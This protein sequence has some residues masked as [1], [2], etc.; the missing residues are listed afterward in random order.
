MTD[1]VLSVSAIMH[2]FHKDVWIH[3][4]V[5]E[6]AV[7]C[8][9]QNYFP[10][11]LRP[12]FV[13]FLLIHLSP[14]QLFRAPWPCLQKA[15]PTPSVTSRESCH[16]LPWLVLVIVCLSVSV[17]ERNLLK[18]LK[19]LD[20][21]LNS[22]LP[23]EIDAYSAEEVAVSG[24]KFLDG[25]ELTL[26]DCN[27]LPKLHIIKVCHSSYFGCWTCEWGFVLFCF[28]LWFDQTSK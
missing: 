10:G 2:A 18:A 19:K 14:S 11:E 8:R 20:T 22:P 28:D 1:I 24:R 7:L 12:L 15:G 23:D 9:Q 5:P 3:R 16:K 27:L 25:D 21:Y 26:A 4:W 17:Y 6:V 13:R